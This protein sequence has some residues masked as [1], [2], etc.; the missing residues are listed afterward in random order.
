MSADIGI[1]AVFQ[2]YLLGSTC[3]LKVGVCLYDIYTLYSL[4]L[5]QNQVSTA[6]KKKKPDSFFKEFLFIQ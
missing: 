5:V 4:K 2:Q 1:V 3:N 6:A